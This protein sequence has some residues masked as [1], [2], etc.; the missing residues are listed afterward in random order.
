MILTEQKRRIA[1]RRRIAMSVRAFLRK[2]DRYEEKD[3]SGH[4]DPKK[5]VT[6][7]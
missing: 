3:F 4:F 2:R 1:M 7:L 6:L 5:A